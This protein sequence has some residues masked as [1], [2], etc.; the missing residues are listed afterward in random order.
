M[1][2]KIAI[3]LQEEVMGNINEKR[4][5]EIDSML[6]DKINECR[7][8]VAG[9]ALELAKDYTK[10]DSDEKKDLIACRVYVI[11][12]NIPEIMDFVRAFNQKLAKHVDQ[13]C[14]ENRTAEVE[15]SKNIKENADIGL[16][17]AD[18]SNDSS[19][20]IVQKNVD[21]AQQ[22]LE[23]MLS[24]IDW[25]NV[26]FDD[27]A[28]KFKKLDP[29]TVRQA[30]NSD[31]INGLKLLF[32]RY[33]LGEIHNNRDTNNRRR[34]YLANQLKK[35]LEM[36]P[37]LIKILAKFTERVSLIQEKK[38]KYSERTDHEKDVEKKAKELYGK[39]KKMAREIHNINEYL[40]LIGWYNDKDG[41]V[42]VP[43]DICGFLKSIEIFGGTPGNCVVI[44]KSDGRPFINEKDAL[45]AVDEEIELLNGVLNRGE[46]LLKYSQQHGEILNKIAQMSKMLASI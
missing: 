16:N 9:K 43:K 31:K 23:D 38:G 25:V 30:I 41:K 19:V 46:D 15:C 22:K 8:N 12:R 14:L 36:M 39:A 6:I 44:N 28:A 17:N 32:L 21:V 35:E 1:L 37:K 18:G 40:L 27:E 24:K 4:I 10:S 7:L 2:L 11:K 33:V 13:I 45:E 26:K 3:L 20:D 5:D 42:S 34:V 29:E